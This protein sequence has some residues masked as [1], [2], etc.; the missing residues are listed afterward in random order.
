MPNIVRP[1]W[2]DLQRL[3]SSAHESL[4]M[5]APYYSSDGIGR[6]FD[7]LQGEPAVTFW[8]RLSPTDWANGISSPEDLLV[9]AQLLGEADLSL[10]LGFHPRL[11]AKAYAAD[12]SELLLGSANLSANGFI[13]NLE[14]MVRFLG[15]EAPSAIEKVR[16]SLAGE[17]RAL[18]VDHLAEWI[19]QHRSNVEV[20]RKQLQAAP[21]E[22]L[23]EAQ[24][25]LD[26]KLGFGGAPTIGLPDPTSADITAF[27]EWL[28]K[29]GGL[30]GAQTLLDRHYN[31]RHDNLT[32]HFN[33]CFTA[34]LRFFHEQSEIRQAVA[35]SPKSLVPDEMYEPPESLVDAWIDHVE[36]H[37]TD[38][39]EGWSYSTLRNILPPA[40]GGTVTGG[41]GGIS[42]LKRMLPLVARYLE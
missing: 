2:E 13:N 26:E 3:I 21:S 34:C 14:L 11:H 33:Q 30:S 4:L 32:G 16:T 22:M 28:E 19:E 24:K 12:E 25:D 23:S 20:V 1:N 41:G 8:G 27:V 29:N 38:N 40:L 42:T 39:G 5:C 7:S 17:I 15:G 31:V 36:S 9:F 10:S 18:P 6:L 35:A 37:A